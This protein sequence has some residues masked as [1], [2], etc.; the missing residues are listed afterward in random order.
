MLP[1]K[2][3]LIQWNEYNL[4]FRL[5]AYLSLEGK[6]DPGGEDPRVYASRFSH[7]TVH[8]ASMPF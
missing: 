5:T 8:W 7:E 2:L 4:N 6:S 3:W 1:Q